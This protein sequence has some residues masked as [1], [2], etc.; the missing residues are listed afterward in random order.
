MGTIETGVVFP[1]ATDYGNWWRI[2]Y[3]DRVGY[4]EKNNILEY[5]DHNINQIINEYRS[6]DTSEVMNRISR[7]FIN[8]APN[9]VESADNI[10]EGKYRISNYGTYDF[11]DG[12]KWGESPIEGQEF[13]RSYYRAL[14]AHFFIEDLI[15]AYHENGNKAYIDEGYKIIEDWIYKNQYGNKSHELAWHDEG[16]SRRLITWINFYDAARDVLDHNKL[17]FLLNN[18]IDHAELLGTEDFH[19]TNT[20]HGMFQDEALIAFSDYFNQLSK[21]QLY[22]VF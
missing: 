6:M 2:I 17:H 10:L 7:F 9:F 20:N 5:K 22:R 4:V 16:T 18:M 13:S 21:S 12:I 11:S 3:L 15:A 1:I 19:T 8:P 14:H